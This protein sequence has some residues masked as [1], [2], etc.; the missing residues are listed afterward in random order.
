MPL[1]K[2]YFTYNCVKYYGYDIYFIKFT[3]YERD[4]IFIGP[5]EYKK[6][7]LGDISDFAMPAT[8]SPGAEVHL[9]P[10]CDV[11]VDDV[12]KEYKIKRKFDDGDYNVFSKLWWW[13]SIYS[14][15]DGCIIIPQHKT[16]VVSTYYADDPWQEALKMFPDCTTDNTIR[17][18]RCFQFFHPGLDQQKE[19]WISLISG[20]AMKPCVSIKDLKFESCNDLDID[21]LNLVYRTSK[22]DRYVQQGEV[23]KFNLQLKSLNQTNWREYPLTMNLLFNEL[24]RNR[25]YST[26]NYCRGKVSTIPKAIKHF[27]TDVYKPEHYTQEDFNMAKSFLMELLGMQETM[28][29]N[30]SSLTE[31]LKSISM[32]PEDFEQYFNCVVRIKSKD[33]VEN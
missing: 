21:A 18:N 26:Y 25:D 14:E 4:D 16:V 7:T 15:N 12:R 33:Y 30:Q 8:V 23:E 22:S 32:K 2:A 28:F 19:S 1:P 31:K 17:I 3:A 24:L 10:K 29:V 9:V 13:P 20:S 5:T 27:Y 11:A 6:L